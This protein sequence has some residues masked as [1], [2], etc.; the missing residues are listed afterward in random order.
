MET[1]KNLNGDSGVSRYEIR[2]DSVAVEFIKGRKIYVYSYASAGAANVER[3]KLL[4]SA[5]RG[6]NSFIMNNVRLLY[7]R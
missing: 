4:A 2:A 3:M 5:G 1:Y 6:L 7:V